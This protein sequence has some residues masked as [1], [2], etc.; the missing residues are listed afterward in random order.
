MCKPRSSIPG[1]KSGAP[2]RLLG[3]VIVEVFS[4]QEVYRVLKGSGC[5][6]GI[7]AFWSIK[8]DQEGFKLKLMG[9]EDTLSYNGV[10]QHHLRMTRFMRASTPL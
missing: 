8:T 5:L 4:R 7:N 6:D 10:I 2:S 9:E 1:S 3:F